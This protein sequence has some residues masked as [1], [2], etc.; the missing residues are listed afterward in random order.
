ML[1]SN[2]APKTGTKFVGAKKTELSISA[3]GDFD[4]MKKAETPSKRRRV[5]R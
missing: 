4:E 3:D 1:I 5:D 2:Y